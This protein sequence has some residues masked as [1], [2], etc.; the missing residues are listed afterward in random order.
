MNIKDLEFNTIVHSAM[1]DV[2]FKDD[3]GNDE[4]SINFPTDPLDEITVTLTYSDVSLNL[5]RIVIYDVNK[6]DDLTYRLSI[7]PEYREFDNVKYI[8]NSK[9]Y[10]RLFGYSMNNA[11][12]RLLIFFGAVTKNDVAKYMEQLPE[13]IKS[14]IIDFFKSDLE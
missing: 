11:Y 5:S 3:S 1:G 7:R 4:Y 13:D 14:V 12:K 8:N 10:E 2:Y 9:L 6:I